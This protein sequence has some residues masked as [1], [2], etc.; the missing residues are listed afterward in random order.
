MLCLYNTVRRDMLRFYYHTK[1]AVKCAV[2][3]LAVACNDDGRRAFRMLVAFFLPD[4]DLH[5]MTFFLCPIF[6]P[7]CLR[8]D[9][10]LR[11]G[12]NRH[13][14]NHS[15][16]LSFWLF[17]IFVQIKL[18][19]A[20]HEYWQGRATL[21]VSQE[22]GAWWSGWQDSQLWLYKNLIL[23]ALFW[24]IFWKNNATIKSYW[25]NDI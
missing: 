24:D 2:C 23:L 22:L 5:L 20:S 9:I 1:N 25:F 12:V 6:S 19:V 11:E 18:W 10:K 8:R 4:D 16:T 15:F 21:R 3:V 13:L 17:Q 14:Q 7:V